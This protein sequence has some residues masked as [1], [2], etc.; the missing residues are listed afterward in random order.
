MVWNFS[1]PALDPGL[2]DDF[3]AVQVGQQLG[4]ELKIDVW[5]VVV[6]HEPF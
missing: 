1:R 6:L 5:G 2:F 4:V 3:L